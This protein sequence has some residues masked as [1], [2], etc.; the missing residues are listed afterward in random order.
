MTYLDLLASRLQSY[1]VAND[2]IEGRRKYLIHEDMWW[3]NR[4]LALHRIEEERA[5]QAAQQSDR[6]PFMVTP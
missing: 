3:M 4:P 2:V 6:D 1:R 5:K